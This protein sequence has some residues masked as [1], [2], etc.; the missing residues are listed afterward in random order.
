M[1]LEV[2]SN[3]QA[4]YAAAT[5]E[6]NVHNRLY[7]QGHVAKTGPNVARICAVPVCTARTLPLGCAHPSIPVA[8]W[9]AIAKR[10]G[11]FCCSAVPPVRPYAVRTIP[12]RA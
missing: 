8:E 1:K 7:K 9:S 4:E 5:C 10:L 3:R 11:C 2:R 6:V 12:K